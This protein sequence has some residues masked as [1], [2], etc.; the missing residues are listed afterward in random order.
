ML[1]MYLHEAYKIKV[2]SPSHLHFF[3]TNLRA[4]T[5]FEEESNETESVSYVIK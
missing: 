1:Q 3:N 4:V 2:K 5:Q